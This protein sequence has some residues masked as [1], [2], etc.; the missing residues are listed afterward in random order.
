MGFELLR[1][2]DYVHLNFSDWPQF[3]KIAVEH[4][5]VP[6]GTVAPNNF[7]EQWDPMEYFSNDWQAVADADARALGAALDRVSIGVGL[8]PPIGIQ[9]G[10]L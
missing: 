2:P 4:G 9:K 1:N 6:A 10:P 3:L 7:P 5:W 8:G